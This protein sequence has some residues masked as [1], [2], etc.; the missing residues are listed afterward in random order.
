VPLVSYSVGLAVSLQVNS[1]GAGCYS[2]VAILHKQNIWFTPYQ[3]Q[4]PPL[5]QPGRACQTGV[6]QALGGGLDFS[7]G[8]C[9]SVLH[10]TM[11]ITICRQLP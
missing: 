8:P 11:N 2:T 9:V 1:R 10:G 3:L 4:L 6:C 7:P 5:V